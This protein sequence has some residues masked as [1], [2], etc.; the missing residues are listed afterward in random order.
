MVC[1]R[2]RLR[3]IS[4]I[5]TATASLATLQHP[6]PAL[7][8]SAPVSTAAHCPTSTAYISPSVTAGRP[9]LSDAYQALIDDRA[10]LAGL[11]PQRCS[12]A[13]SIVAERHTAY[14]VS[15]GSWA[16]GDPGGGIL[17]RVRAMG[18]D[19]TYAGQNV[20]TAH[21][22]TIAQAIQQGDAFFAR[23][24]S[25]GGPHWANI[26]NPNHHYMGLGVAV[27]GNEGDYTIYLTQ[28]FADAD[29]AA[30]AYPSS[31]QGAAPASSPDSTTQA[32]FVTQPLK[33]SAIAHA[34]TQL[35]LR[36]APHGAV[37]GILHPRDRLQ[38]VDL[39]E[40]WAQVR[41]LRDNVYGWAFAGF[42]APATT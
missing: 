23:E 38:I 9:Y 8:R 4:M 21:G 2:A 13:L 35:M 22:A 29:A 37:I 17:G 11:G 5:V 33:V 16:D 15:I 24:A 1:L 30:G 10:T 34:T 6:P 27:L 19:A 20:V 31:Q 39:R 42:L 3:V 32:S 40:G 28:V 26:T 25:S 18:I 12:V 36:T 14:M 41:V 7:G